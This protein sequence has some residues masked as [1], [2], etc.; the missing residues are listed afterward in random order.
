[1]KSKFFALLLG[2]LTSL[3]L[4]AQ[5]NFIGSGVALTF[6][7]DADN[8]YDLGDNYNTLN[9]PV[10]FE[11]WVY[12]TEYSLF[13]PVFAT[14]SHTSGNYYG[15]YVRFDPS[16]KLIFE[17]GSGTGAGGSHRR[18]KITSSSAPLNAWIHI[19]IVAT[20]ITD[21]KFYFNGVVQP[22][23]NTDGTSGVTSIVHNSNHVNFGRY[24]TVHRADG[25]RGTLDEG[26]L[27]NIARTETE[28]RTTMCKKL[29]G[30][31]TGLIGYWKADE[32]YT[33][34]TLDDYSVTNADGT[35]MGI[36]GK[37]TSAAPLGDASLYNYSTDYSGV[38]LNLNSPGGDKMKVNKI[39]NT[40]LGI[41]LYRINSAP[42][43]NTGLE[44]FTNY[45][46][47]VFP[48]DGITAAKYNITYTY[49]FTNGVVNATNEAES[50]IFKKTDDAITSWS[51]L[52]ST[53]N[54][55]TD[56]LIKKNVI[57]RADYIFNIEINAG[58]RQAESNLASIKEIAIYPNPATGIINFENVSSFESMIIV[59]ITGRI[60]L[61]ISQNDLV[62]LQ[63]IDVSGFD[64]GIYLVSAININ[65]ETQSA[66]FVVS[67]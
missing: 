51:F 8:Y 26:R 29:T 36:V 7:G 24:A 65:G 34:T 1:M 62:E 20:T 37:V 46:Y 52:P 64:N 63:E 31:E 59:D 19:A 40:P 32:S 33:S 25:F 11:A 10:T 13:T 57:G 16:G 42:Y 41:H 66:K 12:Q 58:A 45:Y 60:I 5:S 67:H 22:S 30:A 38:Q 61:S 54:T 27:W 3:F 15:L 47:G 9:F 17:I 49:A 21:I 50:S 18:G 23:I 55:T 6:D 14:D 53:L 43:F 48:I 44:S 35:L 2:V 56:K 4:N 28:I 39:L